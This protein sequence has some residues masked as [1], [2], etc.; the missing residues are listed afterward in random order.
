M[1]E[2]GDETRPELCLASWI[3]TGDIWNWITQNYISNKEHHIQI[4]NIWQVS[5]KQALEDITE[6]LPKKIKGKNK[7]FT[8]GYNNAID[9][10]SNLIKKL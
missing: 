4:E 7:E 9:D 5:R 1:K 3:R 2:F 6:G 8:E 10:F